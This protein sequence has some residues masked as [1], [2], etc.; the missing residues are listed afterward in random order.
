MPRFLNLE[1]LR[2]EGLCVKKTENADIPAST[3]SYT[4][5]LLWRRLSGKLS[6][7]ARTNSVRLAWVGAEVEMAVAMLRDASVDWYSH[8]IHEKHPL[9][10]GNLKHYS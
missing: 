5:A 2:K 6:K 8:F 4:V 7:T 1:L 9:V 10:Q 3:I